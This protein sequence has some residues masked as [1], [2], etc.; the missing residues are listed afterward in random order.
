MERGF[1]TKASSVLPSTDIAVVGGGPAGLIAAREAARRGLQVTL[2]EEDEIIGRPERCAGLYSIRG[3]EKIG[4]TISRRYVQNFVWG[5]RINSPSGA[6]LEVS[7]PTPVAVVAEREAFDRYLAEKALASGADILVG[8]RV[9]SCNI[10]G[11]DKFCEVVFEDGSKLS[12]R[13]LVIAEGSTAKLARMVFTG[14]NAPHWLPTIQLIVRKHGLERRKAHIWFKNYLKD[15][16]GYL[17]PINE[18][19]GKLGVAA[20]R[21]PLAKAYRLM[22]EEMPGSKIIGYSAHSIYRG[23]PLE[24][25]LDGNVL[26]VGDVAGQVKATT[27]GGVIAGGICAKAAASHLYSYLE[28]GRRG[29]YRRMVRG[30]YR[31]LR[32]IYWVAKTIDSMSDKALDGL[33]RVAGE[34]G[35][36]KTLS[37]R[38]DMDFQV[39]GLA[40]SLASPAGL[41]FLFGLLKTL[42]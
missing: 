42:L 31:E 38:G 36:S 34:S 5:C 37:R 25:G 35:L 1:E 18:E 10:V 7:S 21:D 15:F 6:V 9:V 23:P 33:I 32:A 16:F 28:E 26:L 8:R 19:V 14:Y 22:R 13:A 11:G 41:R 30:L 3:L 27:G 2:F 24:M 40:E 12:S 39:T 29:V 17:V 4:V 20:R